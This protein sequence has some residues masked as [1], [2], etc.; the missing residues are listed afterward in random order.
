[1]NTIENDRLSAIDIGTNSFHMI[2]VK[3]DADHRFQILDRLKEVVRLGLSSTDMKYITD[4]SMNRGIEVLKRFK[5]L[6]DIHKA[7]IRAVA[8]S[9]VREALNKTEFLRRVKSETDIDIEIISGIEEA[10]LIYLGVLQ[11]LPIYKDKSFI[12]DIGGGSTEFL[13]G[14][15]GEIIFAE[16]LKI[17]AIRYSRKFFTDQNLRMDDIYDCRENVKGMLIPIVREIKSQDVDIYVGSSGTILNIASII[18]AE[19]EELSYQS[20]NNYVFTRKELTEVVNLFLTKKNILE[21]SKIPGLDPA[22]SDIIIAGTI[23]L[24]QIFSELKIK[25]MVISDYALREGVILDSINNLSNTKKVYSIDNIRYKSIRNMM[26][27]YNVEEKHARQVCSL[28]LQLFDQLEKIHKLGVD[29]REYL[30]SSALLHDVGYYIS[31]S[32]HHRHSYYLIRNS[33]LLGFSDREIEIIANISRYHRKSHPK[34][35]HEGFSR[36]SP[37]DQEKV[38]RLSSFIRIADGLDRTHFS[39]VSKIEPEIIGKTIN[40]NLIHKHD[41]DL[42]L[43][44]WG[45]GRKKGLFEEVFGYKVNFNF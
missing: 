11:S 37:D 38:R 14:Q 45:A 9:A 43:D 19:K 34:L 40:L 20:L 16:S 4:E 8:T 7:P 2:I 41:K 32:Q 3:I 10:R 39:I 6:S 44:L 15:K 17:G 1:M 21:I 36:L 12:I 33:Q 28:S 29:D 22:R 42:S 35:K 24:E 26:S 23:I 25:E 5:A 31:H 30:E 13:L 27:N 18:K